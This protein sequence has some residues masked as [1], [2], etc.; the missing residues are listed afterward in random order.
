MN[1]QDKIEIS[2]GVAEKYGIDA[3]VEVTDI[4]GGTYTIWLADDDAR[5]FRLFI[6]K[7]LL[8]DSNGSF[9]TASGDGA[10]VIAYAEDHRD[11]YEAARVAILKCLEGMKG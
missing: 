2:N 8:I 10:S 9:A 5:C 6:D 1:Q 7:H 3:S 4:V 11:K